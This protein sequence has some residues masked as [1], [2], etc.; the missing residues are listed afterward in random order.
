[1]NDFFLRDRV[2]AMEK[3]SLE[4][5]YHAIQNADRNRFT[6]V[7]T[8]PDKKK[9][10]AKNGMAEI[11][12]RGPIFDQNT[13]MTKMFGGTAMDDMK[14]MLS[15][16]ERRDD[17]QQVLLTI[18]SPGG[19]SRQLPSIAKQ[20]RSMK[21]ETTAY[22]SGNMLSAAYWVGSAADKVY[23]GPT[24]S[25]GSIGTYSVL[26]SYA[27]KQMSD[28]IEQKV[29][30]STPKKGISHPSE[31]ISE[32]SVK[33][34]Q[35]QVDRVHEEFVK[36]VSKNRNL[37][38]EYVQNTMANADVKIGEDA[39]ED[40]T[41]G[42][43]TWDEV[44]E[45]F[46]YD[47]DS[48]ASREQQQINFLETRLSS[49]HEQRTKLHNKVSDLQTEIDNLREDTKAEELDRVLTQAIEE[50]HKFPPAKRETLEAKAEEKGVDYVKDIVEMTPTGAAS[51]SDSVQ[52]DEPNVT[53]EEKQNKLVAKGLIP[54][55]SEEEADVQERLGTEYS[56][57]NNEDA[58]YF[59]TYE[60]EKYQV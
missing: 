13:I 32:D 2:W 51:P 57:E 28:G 21:T 42:T 20:I 39:E 36:D 18:D 40:Y 52:T 1:M 22:A 16:A 12:V 25:V 3:S 59:K 44:Y 55:H 15:E 46:E 30:R 9:L 17:V 35:S 7:D 27:D 54:V 34:I 5:L 11:E 45:S 29:I 53:N 49:M 56:K 37:S 24:S 6:D 4:K 50:D 43:M 58:T 48:D 14:K 26:T 60:I 38:K 31:Q 41:D 10:N 33:K 23:A 19:S 8:S 47:A